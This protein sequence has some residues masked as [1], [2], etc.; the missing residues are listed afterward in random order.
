MKILILIFAI[1][2]ARPATAQVVTPKVA[3]AHALYLANRAAAQTEV[4]SGEVVQFR[5]DK[6]WL[7]LLGKNTMYFVEA[8]VA[9]RTEL[10]LLSAEAP[11][12][13][14]AKIRVLEGHDVP[15]YVLFQ[16]R[17]TKW[18]CYMAKYLKR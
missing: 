15:R 2:A 18:Y 14:G 5:K 11:V 13:V 10:L 3:T 12:V 6:V 4:R 9:G 17:E 7:P 1:L 8:K 16:G